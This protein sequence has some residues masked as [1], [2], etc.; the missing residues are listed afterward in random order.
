VWRIEPRWVEWNHLDMPT[1]NLPA[2]LVD[3]KL[4]QISDIHIGETVDEEYIIEQFKRISKINPDILVYTGDFI[5]LV[6]VD[7]APFDQL[8]RIL[9]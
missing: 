4:V 5:S 8:R 2:S 1:S 9:K 6:N 7:Q 3:K